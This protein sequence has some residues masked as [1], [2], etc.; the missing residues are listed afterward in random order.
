[1]PYP[2][3]ALDGSA[4][5]TQKFND[6]PEFGIDPNKR[7][8]ATMVTSM[9]TMVISLDALNAPKTVNNFVFL[10]GYRYY[11]GIIFHRI[12]DGFVCQGGDPGGTGTGGPG[13]RFEDEP[14]KTRYQIGS[15]AMANAGPNTNGSQFFIVTAA[16]CG[17][18]K[19]KHTVFG[20]VVEGMDI[21]DAISNV[22]RDGRDMPHEP[23]TMTVV[24]SE[25]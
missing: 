19:G 1:M 21:V 12:I 4:P 15:M 23:V 14:V 5:K 10:A 2:F 9:G 6:V 13:Y 18:L 11:E 20:Q 8:T 17:W 3:P 25:D 24:I 22:D 16:D 7:Y